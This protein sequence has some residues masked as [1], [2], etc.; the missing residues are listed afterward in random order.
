MSTMKAVVVEEGAAGRLS[1]KEAERPSPKESEALVR[2][3]AVS[4]NRGEVRRAQSADPGYRPGWDLAGT[5]EKAAADGSGPQEGAR[6]VGLLPAGAW[7]EAA[8]VPTDSVAELPEGVSF[9]QAATLP[10]AGLTALYALD[11][12]KGVLERNVLVTGASGG[13]GHFAVQLA[14]RGG[15]RVVALVRR[16]E[17][18]KMAEEAG[19]HS[20]VVGDEGSAAGDLGP[21][22][23]VLDAV[24]GPVL[25]DALAM[26]AP[27]GVC[28]AFGATAARDVTFDL[29]SF[30]RTGGAVLYGFY[31]FHEIKLEPA[32]SGLERLA[33]MVAAGTLRPVMG[34]EASLDEIG[35]IAQ[36]LMDRD[37]S[38]KAVLYV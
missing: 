11:K 34:V 32:A 2:V 7:G 25:G 33:R 5:I 36:R 29:G 1:L 28:V 21:Y 4:L 18:Q 20:V 30:F 24:G 38:G 23:L 26:L 22:D 15:G 35:D 10:V 12:A 9:A 31:L 19:A 8:A 14:R 6:V 27:H 13:A 3:A 16:P 17:N 37:F